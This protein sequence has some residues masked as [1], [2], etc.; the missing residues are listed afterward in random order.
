MTDKETVT[1]VA[2]GDV[3]PRRKE[4]P[5]E[6]FELNADFVRR[7]DIAFCQLETTY[8]DHGSRQVA[9]MQ[10]QPHPSSN[11]KAIKFAGFNVVSFASN[12]CFDW[13][14]RAFFDTI[15]LLKQNDMLVVG[16]GKDINEARQP[17][18]VERKGTKVAF[19]AYN[20][21][22]PMGYAA[23]Y[24]R[25][26]CAPIRIS[27]FY[28]QMDWQ[29]GTPPRIVTLANPQDLDAMRE[30][31][32]KVRQ[33]ADV[34]VV[35]QHAGIHMVPATIAMYQKEIARAAVDAG[36]D[37]VLQHHAH[38]LKGMEVYKGKAVFYGLC[39]W[40][41]ESPRGRMTEAS[42]IKE[43]HKLYKIKVEPEWVLYPFPPDA[44]KTILVKA[45]ISGKQLQKVSFLPC[46][47][48]PKVQ[49]EILPRRDKR[50]E[51]VVRY[52]ED[53]SRSEGLEPKLSWDG[54]EVVLWE[55]QPA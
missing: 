14:E 4:N 40:A 19:L 5:N 46:M 8:T 35:S 25:P 15:E 42:D 12:H 13:G 27:T 29:P 38:I 53:I 20:S 28:E 48:N 18:I 2:V 52:I 16:A 22:L 39:N 43:Q 36:A 31:I 32:K 41:H 3:D 21:I 55:K 10:Y 24:D 23:A 33:L 9:V 6:L 47:I 51:E 34:V 45:L 54:D 1:L 50:S 26:G 7:A 30:D 11:V 49:A 44:R 37:L 17:V